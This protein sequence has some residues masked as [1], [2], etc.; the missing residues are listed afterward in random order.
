[1]I[2]FLPWIV[3]ALQLSKKNSFRG[4]YSRKYG[5][6]LLEIILLLRKF[7]YFTT[8]SKLLYFIR[9]FFILIQYESKIILLCIYLFWILFISSGNS[10]ILNKLFHSHCYFLNLWPATFWTQIEQSCHC[11]IVK[12]KIVG[13]VTCH[14]GFASADNFLM[15]F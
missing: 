1:M 15:E 4:N 7:F 13:Q 14:F 10:F 5:I 12:V 9:K 11:E 8:L 3:A 2:S 6:F